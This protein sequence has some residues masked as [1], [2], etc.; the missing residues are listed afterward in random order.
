MDCPRLTQGHLGVAGTGATPNMDGDLGGLWG[1]A[2]LR[3]AQ[4]H[5]CAPQNVIGAIFLVPK[6]NSIQL[7]CRALEAS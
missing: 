1:L 5:G 4:V 2:G 6:L 3:G 7:Q